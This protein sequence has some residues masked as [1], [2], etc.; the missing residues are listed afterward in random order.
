M[1][2]IFAEEAVSEM[3]VREGR[4]E[5]RQIERQNESE[6]RGMVGRECLKREER[7]RREALRFVFWRN[8]DAGNMSPTDIR[9]GIP[10]S[11]S[12]RPEAHVFPF[13]CRVGSGFLFFP[14]L[15]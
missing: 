5:G 8:G 7:A 15:N 9:I 14:V 2:T 13:L 1:E 12:H 3:A 10:E 11:A 4:G 6:P